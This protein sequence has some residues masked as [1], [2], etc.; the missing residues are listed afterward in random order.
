MCAL[1]ACCLHRA[2]LRPPPPA[3]L[4]AAGTAGR[5]AGAAG[6]WTRPSGFAPCSRPACMAAAMQA[7][8]YTPFRGACLPQFLAARPAGSAALGLAH[9]GAPGRLAP[10]RLTGARTHQPT[11]TLPAARPGRHRPA[12]TAARAWVPA[13]ARVQA[14]EGQPA[15]PP[16]PCAR[17]AHC[18]PACCTQL[19][20]G[21]A[22]PP[23]P[24]A[25]LP[26]APHSCGRA[27]QPGSQAAS[28]GAGGWCGRGGERLDG[29][30]GGAQVATA[31]APAPAAAQHLCCCC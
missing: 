4:Q 15:Q 25:A 13:A 5:H 10:P 24:A 22:G 6:C 18:R 1:A 7:P 23:R 27:R 2:S 21:R 3:A 19:W 26:H 17:R 11:T 9:P 14:E 29:G 30:Q 31:A 16:P 8:A 20:R 12:T 28:N